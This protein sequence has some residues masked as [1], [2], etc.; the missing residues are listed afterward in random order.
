MACSIIRS[1]SAWNASANLNVNPS[2]SRA[3][4]M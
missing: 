1:A 4:P 2:A 3:C